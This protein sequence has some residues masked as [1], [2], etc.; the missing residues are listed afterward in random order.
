MNTFYTKQT[1]NYG[2]K[3]LGNICSGHTY[4]IASHSKT[5]GKVVAGMNDTES[6]MLHFKRITTES[7]TEII[8]FLSRQNGRT[9]DFS[10]GGLLMWVDVFHYEYCIYKDT[11]FI[12][13]VVEN[14]LTK[15][16]F[17]MPVGALPLPEAVSLLRKYCEAKGITLEFS[18]VPV[19]YL[20]D[21]M[22]LAPVK[23]EELTDWADY[24]YDSV[25]LSTLKGK[26]MAKKRNHV[27]RFVADYHNH[28]LIEM[29]QANAVIA[30]EFMNRFELEGDD[31]EMAIIERAQTRKLIEEFIKNP[32][33]MHGAFLMVG[34]TVAAFTIGDMVGDTLFIHVEKALREYNGSYEA[35][36]FFF[37][38]EMC[39]KYPELRYI[40]R[41]DD[42]GDAG[43]RQAKESYKPLTLLRKYNI[44][45]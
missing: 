7:M 5:E 12:K 38:R 19:Q 31:T 2:Q 39:E 27:N 15:P 23:V 18:A 32:N 45:F 6:T 33:E 26:K 35:I 24:L 8:P 25:A 4:I 17:S 14:D 29:T 44:I 40:N 36:N 42:S 34:D 11:L 9:T 10:I 30:L 22:A 21:F 28:S 20:D 13:G 41:E 16:A 43:L 1:E 3:M 37:A